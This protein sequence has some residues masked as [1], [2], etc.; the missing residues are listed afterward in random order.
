MAF[1]LLKKK[2]ED[3]E[4]ILIFRRPKEKL[5]V[6]VLQHLPCHFCHP[7]NLKNCCGGCRFP[8]R[9][10]G[11]HANGLCGACSVSEHRFRRG[12]KAAS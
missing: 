10:V 6:R 12:T 1:H 7:E 9:I 5:L 8:F 2:C 3:C 11:H 4:Q